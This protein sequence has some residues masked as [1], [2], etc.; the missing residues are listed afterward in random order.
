MENLRADFVQFSRAR[1]KTF[2]N[3]PRFPDSLSCLAS[4]YY[5]PST[6]L[7]TRR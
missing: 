7:Y 1:V 2:P 3:S 4:A 6:Q 5:F